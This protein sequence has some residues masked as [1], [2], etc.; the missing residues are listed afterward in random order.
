[1]PLPTHAPIYRFVGNRLR[2]FRTDRQLTQAQVAEVIGVSPQQYQKYEDAQSRATIAL[3][4]LL[5]KFYGL[6]FASF[7]EGAPVPEASV[8]PQMT[9]SQPVN[10]GEDDLLMRLVTAY[11]ALPSKSDKIELVE[12]AEE[13][14]ASLRASDV[15]A[16][17][18]KA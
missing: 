8:A 6:S 17:S 2:K 1:M 12:L 18:S 4:L 7:V 11:S 16:T 13:R 5:S 14:M 10:P 15:P 3:V 9:T